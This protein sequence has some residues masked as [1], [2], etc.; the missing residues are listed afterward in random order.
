VCY[1]GDYVYIYNNVSVWVCVFY[2]SIRFLIVFILQEETTRHQEEQK[3]WV[4]ESAQLKDENEAL[5]VALSSLNTIG[6]QTTLECTNAP[7]QPAEGGPSSVPQVSEGD[8]ASDEGI[9]AFGNMDEA[10]LRLEF[11]K[12]ADRKDHAPHGLS[13]SALTK[14]LS[15]LNLVRTDD[16]IE[17]LMARF[18]LDGNGAIDF[19]E[20][21]IIV[22]LN[23]DVEMVLKT[24]GIERVMAAMMPTGSTQDPLSAFFDMDEGQVK[25][26]V[27]A[28]V[29]PIVTLITTAIKKV[30]KAKKHAGSGGESKFDNPL[31]G[32]PVEVFYTGVTGVVGEPHPDLEMGV[33]KEH[34]QEQDSQE[35]FTTR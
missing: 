2:S 22:R 11:E 29:N 9:K 4:L 18:D 24:L 23:S 30:Q 31:K 5:K 32:G 19:D 17:E 25:A 16:E 7:K 27:V 13:Q 28:A 3:E 21:C 6:P 34:R 14:A 1:D 12:F 10:T 26:A 20:F 15:A 8:T 35:L 33:I